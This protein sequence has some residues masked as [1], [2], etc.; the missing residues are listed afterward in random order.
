MKRQS[1]SKVCL[2][3]LAVVAVVLL[4]SPPTWADEAKTTFN[5][6]AQDLGPALREFARQSNREILFSSEVVKGMTT[7]GVVGALGAD[8]ALTQLLAGTGLVAST[9]A[10]GQLLISTADAKGA[11]ASSGPLTAPSGATNDQRQNSQTNRTGPSPQPASL[12]EIIVTAQKRAERL[13]DVPVPV[14]V[15]DAAT[16]VSSNKSSISDYFSTVPG[17]SLVPFDTNGAPGLAIRGITTGGFTDPT[18]AVTIDDISF[19]ASTSLSGGTPALDLDPSDLDSIEVLRGPQGTLYGASSLGGLLKYV[20]KAPS[21]DQFEGRI[22][23]GASTVSYAGNVGYV[24]RA[25]VNVPVTDTFAFRASAFVRFDPG[26]IDNVLTGQHDINDS[27][28]YGGRLSALWRPS[29]G[30]SIRASAIFQDTKTNGFDE[31][32]TGPP[33]NLAARQQSVVRGIGATD[34]QV[35]AYD[36]IANL[37]LGAIELTS[38][39]GYSVN[40]LH[41]SFDLSAYLGS[42]SESTFG[43]AGAPLS[44]EY[45]TTKISQEFRASAH[46]GDSVDWRLGAFFTAEHSP[47]EQ[48]I[49]AADP[50]SDAVVGNLANF[51]WKV[52]YREYAAFSDATVRLSPSF[53]IQFGARESWIEQT[54]AEVD[55]GPY[56]AAYEDGSPTI[57]PKVSTSATAFTYLVTPRLKL[58]SDWMIYARLA[59]GFRPGGPNS[60]ASVFG[61]PVSYRPDTTRNYEVGVKGS[62]LDNRLFVDASLYYID[63]RSIQ[64]SLVD[65]T[66]GLTYYANGSDA[67]S[68]GIE[69]SLTAKPWRG[70]AVTAWGAWNDAELTQDLPSSSAVVGVKGDAL[71]FSTPYSASLSV[72]QDFPLLGSWSGF[73]GGQDVYVGRRLGEFTSPPAVRQTYTSYMKADLRAGA[74]SGPWTLNLFAN[75]VADSRGVLSGGAGSYLPYA[76]RYLHPRTVGISVA[77]T[78]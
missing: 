78:F 59:S 72:Q 20:T 51:D 31:E 19:G 71:P 75:N 64:L 23:T 60:T 57:F 42:F 47:D 29:E 43:V 35:Q 77:W 48:Q 27:N 61:L 70:L 3:I 7:K 16:L 33:Y 44:E 49:N 1:I 8:A 37:N 67:K 10:S 63:W 41:D 5:I 38:L 53:D 62:A 11:S 15:L 69:L 25:S 9:S 68:Q 45:V 56:A 65:P 66:N 76:F 24:D 4:I 55:T 6:P 22:E 13:Q 34:H 40:D 52:N 12:E 30:F 2:T 21:L 39:T 50:Q 36:V 17:L 18:V 14:T 46:I 26:Y 73:V 58:A 74:K 32:D 28:A 54:Y